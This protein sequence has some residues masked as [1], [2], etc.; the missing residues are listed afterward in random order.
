MI[1]EAL[2]LPQFHRFKE[3]DRWWG[4]GFTEWFNVRNANP[5]FK[6]HLI[7]KKSLWGEYDLSDPNIMAKQYAYAKK[8]GVDVFSVYHYWSNG[9]LLMEK[10]IENLL[11]SK[12]HEF[13]FY[14]NWA[15]HSFFNKVDGLNKKL[16]WKQKYCQN[17]IDSHVTYL[18]HAMQDY[19]YHRIHGMP[20]FNI[21]DPRNI[22]N[23]RSF[24]TE[25]KERFLKKYKTEIHLRLTLKDYKDIDL[26]KNNIDLID[27]VYE[28]QPFFINHS[29]ILNYYSY[30]F[31]LRLRRDFMKKVSI[32]NAEKTV[33]RIVKSKKCIRGIPYGIGAYTG[34]DTTP[35]WGE[36]GIIHH[37]FTHEMLDVQINAAKEKADKNDFVVITAWN[38]WGEGAI[39]EP[40]EERKPF[41]IK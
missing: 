33:N 4:E 8:I 21:Y 12:N 1:V 6:D 25:Y 38:E 10:P 31:L 11:K 22:P 17:F 9:K 3:N 34:W 15:N 24:V 16:L 26:I 35:R 36:K 29:N 23:F 41:K 20:V 18:N 2:Y 14:L 5:I 32:F 40:C 28:Y 39:M 37:G 7:L 19:R 27:S 13:K 30:E